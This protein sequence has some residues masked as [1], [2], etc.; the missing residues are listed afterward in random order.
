MSCDVERTA[1]TIEGGGVE[2]AS[3][4][5]GRPGDPVVLLI[6]GTMASMLWWPEGFCRRLA[7]AGR[8]VIRYDHR[9][10]GRSTRYPPGAPGYDVGD[11]AGDAI[12]VLDGWSVPAAHVVGMSL[13]GMIAQRVA[14]CAPER[15][16]SLTALSSTPV[17]VEGL[18]GPSPAYL[19]HGARG[20][21]VDWSDR[22]QVIDYMAEDA[23]M[24]AGTAFAHDAAAARA[25]VA[26]DFDRAGGF[27][28][29]TNHF[30]LGDGRPAPGIDRL[31]APLLVIHGTADPIFAPEHGAALARK[32]AGAALVTLDGG[33][34]ELHP[35]HW[36]A[37][38]EA[39][40]AHSAG[41][42]VAR[43]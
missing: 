18:S 20:E 1:K 13:G 17:G 23:R 30:M 36:P 40:V 39:I 12:R 25:L 2:I 5:F 4:A 15:V 38:V 16:L 26:E 24:L 8:R 10:T 14:L 22:G 31:R 42:V 34:H 29:A 3:E 33:G 11:M 9:D 7:V 27:A 21:G 35:G 37:I 6:M 41:Q 43:P 28:S 19:E 32:V